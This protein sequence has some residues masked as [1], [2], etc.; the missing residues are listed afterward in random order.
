MTSEFQHTD[1]NRDDILIFHEALKAREQDDVEVDFALHEK[2]N[3]EVISNTEG[4]PPNGS[5]QGKTAAS[6]LRRTPTTIIHFNHEDHT[7]GNILRH[8]LHSRVDVNIA[9]Y[10]IPHPLQPMMKL[11]VQSEKYGPQLVADELEKIGSLC[12]DS[13]NEFELALKIFSLGISEQA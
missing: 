8:A 12:E 10:V 13:C 9:G 1:S 4:N 6:V 2:V 3:I 5:E 7:L 11:Q